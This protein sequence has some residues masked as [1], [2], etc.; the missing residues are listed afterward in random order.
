M[1]AS[2]SAPGVL[3]IT[4]VLALLLL[5]ATVIVTV[6]GWGKLGIALLAYAFGSRIPVA[7][8]MFYAMR[9][10]WGT[11]YD[12]LPGNYAGPTSFMGRYVAEGLIP[13]IF[14]WIPYTMIM[15]SLAAGVYL[16]V[17]RRGKIV[18]QPA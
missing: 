3:S 14:A 7:I 8:V 9:G 6:M 11:H 2:K 16:A 13:Q 12:A 10:N 4:A 15:G 17:A 18:P 1:L 5:V